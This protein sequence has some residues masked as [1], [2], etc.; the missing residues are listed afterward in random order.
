MKLGNSKREFQVGIF[1]CTQ[2]IL[3][4]PRVAHYIYVLYFVG[5]GLPEIRVQEIYT[6]I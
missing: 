5:R 4:K 6:S 3:Y 2:D 1:T